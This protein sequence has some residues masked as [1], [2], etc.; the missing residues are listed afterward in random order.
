MTRLSPLVLV[1]HARMRIEQEL[2]WKRTEDH[3]PPLPK[4]VV[5]D[6]PLESEATLDVR[7]LQVLG[8]RA[9][10]DEAT[11]Q[12]AW[13]VP[14]GQTPHELGLYGKLHGVLHE[15]PEAGDIFLQRALRG[16]VHVHAGLVMSVEGTGSF[17]DATSFFETGTVEGDTNHRGMLGAGYTC[18]LHRQLSPSQGDRF[19]RWCDLPPVAEWTEAVPASAMEAP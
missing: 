3:A 17:D 15:S 2:K 16:K 10:F 8:Y 9:Y 6:D 19:L 7:L 14:F 18:K 1:R 13:P 4:G 12:S 11:Q 5:S